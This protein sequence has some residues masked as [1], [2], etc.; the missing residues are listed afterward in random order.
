MET[1]INKI[2]LLVCSISLLFPLA[3]SAVQN[4]QLLDSLLVSGKENFE[5]GRENHA[6]YI[7]LRAKEL[8][9]DLQDIE[10]IISINRLFAE[11]YEKQGDYKSANVYLRR[12]QNIQDSLSL[13]QLEQIYFYEQDETKPFK[14]QTYIEGLEIS[15]KY[16]FNLFVILIFAVMLISFI[17]IFIKGKHSETRMQLII[18]EQTK[19]LKETNLTLEQKIKEKAESEEKFRTIYENAPIMIDAFSEDGKCLLWNKECEKQLGWSKDDLNNSGDPLSLVYPIKKER[20]QVLKWIK[21]ADGSFNENIA[22]TKDGSTKIQLWANYRLAPG[23]CLCVGYDITE[24]KKSEIE[25]IESKERYKQLI[26]NSPSLIIEYDPKTFEI[27]SCNPAM[28][29]SLGTTVNNILGKD[30][31]KFA[32]EEIVKSRITIFEKALKEN[33]TI[34]F[35]DSDKG[36]FFCNT[37]IPLVSDNKTT[38]QIVSY[39]ITERKQVEIQLKARE[40]LLQSLIYNI[41]LEF[42]ARDKDRKVFM[43]SARSIEKWGDLSGKTADYHQIDESIKKLWNK[44]LDSAYADH[45]IEG[46]YDIYLNN[47]LHHMKTILAPIKRDNEIIGVLGTDIDITEMKENEKK[48]LNLKDDLENMV[49]AEIEKRKTQQ[50]LLIQKSKLESL[51]Q[52]AAGIAHEINQ[53]VGLIALGVDNISE[54]LKSGSDVSSQY[55]KEKIDKFFKYIDRIHQIIDHIS[56]FSRDQKDITFDEVNINTI[57]EQALAMIRLQYE[58][59]EI[60]FK[61]FL[62]ENLP[63]ILGNSFKI[64]QVLLNLLSN[65]RDALETKI[66]NN[67]VDFQKTITI[68]TFKKGKHIILEFT[69]NGIGMSSKEIENIFDPFYTTKGPKM[70]T[71]LGLSICY[72]ILE[73]MKAEISVKSI[74]DEFTTF[75]IKFQTY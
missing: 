48:L 23:F 25:L 37:V 56:T 40:A 53:P 52:L 7:L 51:G 71:G 33:K 36:R 67:N 75:I 13:L 39:D 3:L 57:I 5:K 6:I 20:E 9:E 2:L 64:E 4:T 55:L 22:T 46:E 24:R 54:R 47:E 49:E 50:E 16:Q 34:T 73:E 28:A 31:R 11:I 21:N 62:G 17:I 29:R 1:K 41:P 68:K 10:K 19:D 70:G 38:L 65:S 35:E 45:E 72:G 15:K 12:L 58:D 59:H 26:V 14:H 74:P 27:L 44:W 61:T 60:H 63:M 30:A 42:Y 66:N 8:A 18:D 69:D 43:Q 32:A